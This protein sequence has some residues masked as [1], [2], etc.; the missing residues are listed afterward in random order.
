[1][2]PFVNNDITVLCFDYESYKQFLDY[3]RANSDTKQ[4]LVWIESGTAFISCKDK[5]SLLKKGD[6]VIVPKGMQ[7]HLESRDTDYKVMV[8]IFRRSAFSKINGDDEFLRAFDSEKVCIYSCSESENRFVF[9]I[10]QNLKKRLELRLG[11]V[12]IFACVSAIV[13]ELDVL[14]DAQNNKA[15]TEIKKGTDNYGVKIINYIENHFTES[16][17]AKTIEE[18]FFVSLNTLNSLCY[19]HAD[20]SFWQYVIT[21]RMKYAKELMM[22]GVSVNQAAAM[23]GYNDY[24]AFYRA[25][26]GHFGVAPSKD[27]VKKE[28]WPL[29][30]K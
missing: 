30:S 6:L 19:R 5:N 17:S 13:S 15:V 9:S 20:M 25:Y 23:C 4:Y 3:K 26:K 16:I 1:M 24:S 8:I 2:Y 14:H 28:Y 21:L 27:K 12:H 18:K 7:F 10:L 22:S 29:S 11:Y